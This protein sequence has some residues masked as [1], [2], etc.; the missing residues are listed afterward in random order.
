MQK[1][2]LF[3]QK[4]LDLTDFDLVFDDMSELI[5]LV[6]FILQLNFSSFFTKF[7]ARLGSVQELVKKA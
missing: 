6:I 3:N 1:I 5:E 7:L 4:K 2:C